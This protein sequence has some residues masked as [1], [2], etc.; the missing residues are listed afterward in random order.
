MKDR[1][2]YAF[3]AEFVEVRVNKWTHKIRVDEVA[4]PHGEER[5]F[6]RLEP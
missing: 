4:D 6:A 1:I 5:A 3:G 2:A